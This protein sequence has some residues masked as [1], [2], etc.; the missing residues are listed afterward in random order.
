VRTSDAMV[1]R[2][3]AFEG[4][5][6]R[7]YD[8]GAGV[9]TVGHG[10]TENVPGTGWWVKG[11]NTRWV[12]TA[13]EQLQL[14]KVDLTRKYEPYVNQL[15][16]AGVKLT[17]GMYDAL[18]SLVYNCGG[19]AV[20]IGSTVGSALRRHDWDA[21]SAGFLIWSKARIGGSGPPVVWPGLLERRKQERELFD[22]YT[23]PSYLT[24]GEATLA[25]KLLDWRRRGV[26]VAGRAAA[27][28]AL[29]VK[30]NAIR[31]GSTKNRPKRR[32]FIRRIAY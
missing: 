32:A 16:K 7:I 19:G 14:L 21:A 31:K 15:L 5:G 17:Q 23:V 2:I 3:A 27:K 25:R 8:D 1:H 28:R 10:H 4:G 22:E 26:N 11:Q 29:H 12:L 24:A 20:A 9:K 18:V 30:Y 6:P 13:A